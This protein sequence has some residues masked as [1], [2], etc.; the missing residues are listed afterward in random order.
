LV[1]YKLMKT[2]N[3]FTKAFLLFIHIRLLISIIINYPLIFKQTLILKNK[4]QIINLGKN[5]L[6]WIDV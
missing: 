5:N 2:F 4:R 6:K 1:H 3:R